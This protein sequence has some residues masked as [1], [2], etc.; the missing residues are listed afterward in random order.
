MKINES[1]EKSWPIVLIQTDLSKSFFSTR[2]RS[3]KRM[4]ALKDSKKDHIRSLL[5]HRNA[6]SPSSVDNPVDIFLCERRTAFTTRPIDQTAYFLGIGLVA[7]K[8]L[9]V[10]VCNGVE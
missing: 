1:M 2:R 7:G 5:W 6:Q 10:V 9:F 8:P 4:D 3:L